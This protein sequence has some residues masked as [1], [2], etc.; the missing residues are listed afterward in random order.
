MTLAIHSLD[1]NP[2]LISILSIKSLLNILII[3]FYEKYLKLFFIYPTKIQK[4]SNFYFQPINNINFPSII[5]ISLLLLLL[6][7]AIPSYIIEIHLKYLPLSLHPPMNYPTTPSLSYSTSLVRKI[8]LR[9]AFTW[10]IS[11]L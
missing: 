1:L 4:S 2:F 11:S 3:L 10:K 5:I 7:P 9:T 8:L 6:L